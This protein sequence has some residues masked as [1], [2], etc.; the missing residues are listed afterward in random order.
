[1][2]AIKKVYGEGRNKYITY[3]LQIWRVRISMF[4]M[5]KKCDIRISVRL[6]REW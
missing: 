1:M 5:G 4:K 3:D 6:G 2:V